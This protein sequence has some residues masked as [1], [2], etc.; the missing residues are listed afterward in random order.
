MYDTTF[1]FGSCSSK[2]FGFRSGCTRQPAN[3]T[4]LAPLPSSKMLYLCQIYW[5]NNPWNRIHKCDCAS[6]VI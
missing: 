2:I 6:N 1:G 5:F 3:K 4:R